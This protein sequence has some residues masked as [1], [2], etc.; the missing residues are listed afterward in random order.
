MRGIYN[1]HYE[2][3]DASK[4]GANNVYISIQKDNYNVLVVY[5]EYIFAYRSDMQLTD[6]TISIIRE[7][8]S[9][10]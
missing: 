2:K 10:K 8:L 9:L 3:A 5:D 4:W 6:D 7:K 1:G